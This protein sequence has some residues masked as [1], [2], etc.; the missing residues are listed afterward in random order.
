MGSVTASV[1][2][3]VY[4][5]EKT[6]KR[7]MDSLLDQTVTDYE[8]IAVDDGSKDGSGKILDSYACEK[9]RIIHQKNGGVSK[10]RNAGLDAAQGD[11]ILFCD[12]DD[13]VEKN[14]VEV[15]C[16]YLNNGGADLVCCCFNSIDVETLK[17]TERTTG[18]DTPHILKKEEFLKL[19]GIDLM[20]CGW[21]KAYRTSIIRDNNIRFDEALSCGE[22][23]SFTLEY[24]RRSEKDILLINDRLYN[25]S[26]RLGDNL[27]ARY[28]SDSFFGKYQPLFR[29]YQTAVEELHAVR[30]SNLTALYTGFFLFFVDCLLS[31][32]DRRCEFGFFKKIVYCH[33]IVT[34]EEFRICYDNMDKSRF[35]SIY[36]TVMKSR[37]ALLILAFLKLTK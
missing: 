6:L 8:I 3:P 13:Y 7:C 22:D 21:D 36:L 10:A 25:Y 4:N 33:K 37:C 32:W 9:V 2:V 26:Y 35:V 30:D 5:A 34:S 19:R 31:T 18:F 12:S 29:N 11:I 15:L 23:T 16:S 14:F 17:V 20:A 24:I 27:A 28:T 1:I